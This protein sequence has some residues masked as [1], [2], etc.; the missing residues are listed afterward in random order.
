M[1]NEEEETEEE[2]DEG[3]FINIKQAKINYLWSSSKERE[4]DGKKKNIAGKKPKK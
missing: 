2:D 4:I 1:E 3:F